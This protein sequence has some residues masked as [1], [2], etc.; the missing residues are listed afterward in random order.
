MTSKSLTLITGG[1]I[2]L[3]PDTDSF[4]GSIEPVL[5]SADVL[6]GHLEVLFTREQPRAKELGREPDNMRILS[7]M[8][9]DV[10]TLAHNHLW[11]AGVRGISDTLDWLREHHISPVGA[12]MNIKEARQPV[13]L[14][15]E[16]TRFGFLSYNC[17]GPRET[18]AA[19]ERPGCAYV[20]ILTHYELDYASPGGPPDIYTFPQPN[21]LKA[22]ESD[23]RQLRPRCDIL[24]VSL[25]KGLVHT[26]VTLAQYEQ[27]V[28][29]AAIDAGAD[30]ILGHHAHILKG[31]EVYRGKVIF[32][33][34]GNFVTWLPMLALK[35]GQDKDSWA[36]RRIKIFGFVPD[37][38][39]PT[40]PFHP[41]AVN[42]LV[43]KLIIQDHAIVRVSF[44]PCLVHQQGFPE[45]I[46]H[47]EKGQQVFDY[48]EKI[49]RGAELN[50]QFEWDG[51]E[52][53]I[54]T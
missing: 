20:N 12:G 39:Y 2:I 16:G 44:I 40:Y 38:D 34:L 47:P 32:H 21:S 52:V 49:T 5:K 33:S 45:V 19:D 11:D 3:G 26:P 10:L 13:I 54:R 23:I 9:F 24:V 1:D 8:G 14:E 48:M 7:D 29:H 27:T 17:V 30:L 15:K 50:G 36:R 42:A 53:L 51:D 28:S 41:E 37:P 4:F 43:A 18:W 31:I 46:K 6:V 35:P 25:H 22:M